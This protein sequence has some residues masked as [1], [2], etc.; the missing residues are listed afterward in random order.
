ME[1]QAKIRQILVVTDGCS[2]IGD[3]PIE[4]ARTARRKGIVVNVIGVVD[5][6]D[7]GKQGREEAMSIADA[8]GGM[9]RIVHPADLAAT[10]Q[11]LTH[12]TMQ[13]TLQQVVNK[14]LL[15]VMGQ[16]TED[17]PPEKRAAVMQVVDKLEEE[18]QLELI[19][20]VDTSASMKEK[21][22]TVREAIRDLSISL[23]ARVGESQVA[24]LT[25]P[26]IGEALTERAQ[27][28]SDRVDMKQLEA[29]FIARGGTPTA[30]A[31]HEA[32]RMFE[33]LDTFIDAPRSVSRRAS[34]DQ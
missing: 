27:E 34:S 12:Q 1:K 24:V 3:D 19:V 31:I 32:I 18:L 16:Q 2:N 4:A 25:F 22:P 5:K 14:E 13:L 29:V 20:A 8:G 28:F 26:G 11:M 33:E 7:M 21:I 10:A 9:C 23:Q 15:Q 6:G 30:P 17:L